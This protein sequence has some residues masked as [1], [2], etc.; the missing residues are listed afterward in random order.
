MKYGG[1][2]VAVL[3]A[4]L[5]VGWQMELGTFED[6]NSVLLERQGEVGQWVPASETTGQTLGFTDG[7]NIIPGRSK[8]TACWLWI[9]LD[10]GTVQE[11]GIVVQVQDST[12]RW[13]TICQTFV[14]RHGGYGN[15][16]DDDVTIQVNPNLVVETPTRWR[17]RWQKTFPAVRAGF[18]GKIQFVR[19]TDIPEPEVK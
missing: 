18:V 10:P 12:G 14:H 17:V 8:I 1:G 5:I 13:H 9:G 19:L 6:Q 15:Y 4:S 16:T 11:A 7:D 3:L 2:L